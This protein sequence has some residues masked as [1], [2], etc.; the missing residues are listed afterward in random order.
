MILITGVRGFAGRHLAE[1]SAR[2]GDSVSGLGRGAASPGE[3]PGV[4]E[5][6]RVDLLDAAAT[7]DAVRRVQPERVFHLAAEASVARSWQAPAEVISAN[8]ASTLN[9]LEAVRLEAPN[10]AVLVACSAAEYGSPLRSPVDEEHP[11]SPRNP[12]GA[13]KAMVDVLAGSY[14]DSHGLRV[15]RM[16]AF[17]H[18]GPGQSEEYVVS[19]FARQIANAEAAGAPRASLVT[20]NISVRRDFTDVRDAVRAYRLALER[21]EPGAYNVCSGRAV[22]LSD[23]LTRLAEQSPLEVEQR[24]D[25]SR[26]RQ[27]DVIEIAGSHEKL[28]AATG[29]RPEI[30]LADTLRDVLAW[31]RERAAG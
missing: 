28:T 9:L 4:D 3:L 11:L 26:L 30:D 12:Y 19:S 7:R 14:A 2:S 27:N 1:L 23:I 24:V 21:A 6:L 31:W 22:A 29:W 13:S 17:N 8:F 16:R 20:G 10:A 18:I 5:Y 25:D 15:V